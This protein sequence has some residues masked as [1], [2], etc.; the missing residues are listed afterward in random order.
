MA[1]GSLPEHGH[2]F[3]P[4]AA[5]QMPEAM[6]QAHEF[7]MKLRGRVRGAHKILLANPT[8]SQTIGPDRRLL[9]DRIDPAIC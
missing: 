9:P 3:S 7:T 8:L 5:E 2:Q 1:I 4:R 6:R